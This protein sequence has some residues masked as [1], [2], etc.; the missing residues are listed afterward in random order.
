MPPPPSLPSP[1]LCISTQTWSIGN[2]KILLN[3][4]CSFQGARFLPSDDSR[5]TMKQDCFSLCLN[6][7]RGRH[8]KGKGKGFWA[9]G[10][11][12]GRA[13][14]EGGRETPARKLLFSPSRLLIM[15]AKIT[16]P[17]NDWLSNKSG[18][19]AFI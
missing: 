4:S 6:S 9:R 16:Q 11:R 5:S 18:R 19:D 15:C 12:E 14:R 13:R 1:Q 10:K 7:L 8:F 2:V 3:I 17:V